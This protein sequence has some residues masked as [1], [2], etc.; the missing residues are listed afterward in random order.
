MHACVLALQ[1]CPTFVPLWTV[2]R[3]LLYPWGFSR[4]EYW[5]R[6]PCPLSGHLPEPEIETMSL[7]SPALAAGIFNTSI[8]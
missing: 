7:T 5:S 2:A 8:T 6:L 3:R 1:S 4:Q